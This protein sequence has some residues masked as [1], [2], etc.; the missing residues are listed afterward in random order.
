LIWTVWRDFTPET[1][2]VANRK[3]RTHC[4]TATSVKFQLVEACNPCRHMLL[5]R[6]RPPRE[7][8]HIE[9]P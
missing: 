7:K 3:D 8:K 6:L 2:Q 4:L 9:R 1:E 5:L